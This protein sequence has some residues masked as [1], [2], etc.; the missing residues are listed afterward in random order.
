MVPRTSPHGVP[1][2]RPQDPFSLIMKDYLGPA[3]VPPPPGASSLDKLVLRLV[4]QRYGPSSALTVAAAEVREF[5]LHWRLVLSLPRM[6]R[7]LPRLA[8]HSLRTLRAA[9]PSPE[10]LRSLEN[11]VQF[12]VQALHRPRFEGLAACRLS[13]P[14]QVSSG[15]RIGGASPQATGPGPALAGVGPSP[16]QPPT[17]PRSLPGLWRR[18][19]VV[20]PTAG[21]RTES[22]ELQEPIAIESSGGQSTATPTELLVGHQ[23]CCRSTAETA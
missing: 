6:R 3:P 5:A 1:H 13:S 23:R 11:I 21:R 15:G 10:A 17:A 8:S 4:R 9:F 12:I 14:F 18:K 16:L 2:T 22:Q 19:A 20:E 7:I